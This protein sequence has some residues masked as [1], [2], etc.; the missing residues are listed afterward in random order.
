[1]WRGSYLSIPLATLLQKDIYIYSMIKRKND[2][3]IETH[4]HVSLQLQHNM[5]R[6]IPIA[7][8]QFD[9]SSKAAQIFL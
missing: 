4:H 7:T 2:S 5:V 1:M 6:I 3:L 8:I 9:R